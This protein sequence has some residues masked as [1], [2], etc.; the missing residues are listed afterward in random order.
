[1]KQPNVNVF[2]GLAWSAAALAALLPLSA[3]AVDGTWINTD[4][5][6]ALTSDPANWLGGIIGGGT[7]STLN[8]GYFPTY[9]ITGVTTDLGAPV[10]L[11]SN[12]TAGHLVLEDY[13]NWGSSSVSIVNGGASTP[14]LTF[15]T[16]GGVIPTALTGQNLNSIFGGKK[17]ILNT[18]IVAGNDGFRKTG[19][20]YLGLRQVAGAANNHTFTGDMRIEGGILQLASQTVYAGQTVVSG[21]STLFLDYSNANAPATNMI[22]SA[23]VLVLGSNGSGGITRGGGVLVNSNKAATSNASQTW[24]STTL[25]EGANVVRAASNTNQNVTYNLGAVTRNPGAMIDFSRTSANGTVVFGAAIPNGSNGIVGGWAVASNTG[26]TS[27]DWA[28]NNGSDQM[29][30][31]T[32]YSANVFGAGVHTNVTGPVAGGTT[33]T[34][35]LN[36]GYSPTVTFGG[37]ATIESGGI[38]AGQQSPLL[39]G[40]AITTGNGDNELYLH[41]YGAGTGLRIASDIVDNGGPV[42]VLKGGSGQVTL[43]NN[44]SYTGGTYIGGGI[45]QVG[46][47]WGGG[48]SGSI[49]GDV[50]VNGYNVGTGV[51]QPSGTLMMNRS[52]TVTLNN[53]VSGSGV[54]S[55]V[56][57]NGTLVLNRQYNVRNLQALAGNVKLDFNA[58]SAPSGEIINSIETAGSGSLATAYLLMRNSTLDVQGKDGA[59]STQSF[60]LTTVHGAARINLTAGAGGSLTLNLGALGKNHNSGEGGGTLRLNIPASGVTVTAPNGGTTGQTQQNGIIVDDN[61]AYVTIGDNDWAAKDATVVP[62]SGLPASS[63]NI[64]PGSSIPGFYTASSGSISGNLD[65]D[66]SPTLG[67]TAVLSSMRFNTPGANTVTIGAGFQLEPHGILVGTNVGANNVTIAGPGTIRGTDD[68]TNAARDLPIIQNN[69]AGDLVISAPIVN[70]DAD[71]RTTL[72]KSGAGTLALN[73]GGSGTVTHSF[74]DRLFINEGTVKVGSGTFLGT[75]TTRIGSVLMRGGELIVENDGQVNSGAFNS[76][77]QRIGEQGALTL[78]NNAVYNV[79][80]DFNVGDVSAKGTLTMTDNSTL[81]IK[82]FYAGKS[83]FAEGTVNLSGNAQILAANTPTG[84]WNFGGNSAADPTAK[85]VMNMSGNSVFDA[86]NQNFQVGRNGIGEWN[87]TGGTY[88]SAGFTVLGR[89]HTG[90]G[91]W[92][93]SGGTLDATTT[94]AP[95]ITAQAAREY[96]ILGEVGTG[97][98]NVSG[99]GTAKAVSISLAHNG[100]SGTLNVTG[101]LV[102]LTGTA[103]LTNAIQ[104]GIVFSGGVTGAAPTPSVAGGP[105]GTVNLDGGTIKAFGVSERSGSTIS[106]T[107]NFNGGLLQ[108]IGNNATFLQGLD[109]ANVKTGGAKI[110]TNGFGVTVAQGLLHSGG[111]PD[112]GLTKQGLGTL[113]LTGI[114]TYD[115]N[116]LI[117]AG[118]LGLSGSG[119]I[120][121]SPL[122]TVQ[123]PASFD[124]SAVPGFSLAASQTLAGNG[125]VIGAVQTMGTSNISPGENIGTLNF[126]NNLDISGLATSSGNLIFELD[127]PGS[128][129]LVSL[130]AAATL[131]I[132]TLDFADFSFTALGGFGPGTYTLFDTQ[133]PISGGLGGSLSGPIG[134]Y[135][136]TLTTADGG[137]D[138]VLNVVIPE[139]S[140]SLLLLGLPALYLRRKRNLT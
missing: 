17:A 134:A 9:S 52:G 59:S 46:G 2:A 22:N 36:V 51:Y 13:D 50:F 124:V 53:N 86:G 69:T 44:M 32:T 30:A 133:L 99:T 123:S 94:T 117:Q 119:S 8:F 108:A 103:T 105:N 60:G 26:N 15:D 132:G 78:K 74:T 3:P 122:I 34:L 56:A 138:L 40:G 1:M 18:L 128:S 81:S 140:V 83:G 84:E 121:T 47:G 61:T 82:S 72:V 27:F 16:T 88:R 55:Q 49:N 100:G 62:N 12:L 101:G 38:L 130:G 118:T 57:T 97:I 136:G 64:V 91:T 19:P 20:G 139:P 75:T 127:S 24:A 96:L 114:S 98:L 68:A 28:M 25:N 106:S 113:T 33:N 6:T 110:D 37:A 80:G 42:R 67:A 120:A 125:N 79:N 43:L 77:G 7:D 115:G 10:G 29:T 63:L 102:D 65:V 66:S 95:G 131:N 93:L 71:T 92:N 41:G 5:G 104:P 31:S 126:T 87:Q 58:G 70:F 137:N 107:F 54:I 112:G 89:F 76:L 73:N 21:G 129:D 11:D 109:A 116:T 85:G 39:T 111:S 14:V 35:R 45:L 4:S 48:S 135:V 90:V 23:S